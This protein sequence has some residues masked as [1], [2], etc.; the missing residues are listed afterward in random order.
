MHFRYET[1]I[2]V[3]PEEIL[4]M[5]L[6]DE[7]E[8]QVLADLLSEKGVTTRTLALSTAEEAKDFIDNLSS[9]E[10]EGLLQVL[11]D[12]L[13]DRSGTGLEAMEIQ[14][15][16]GPYSAHNILAGMQHMLLRAGTEGELSEDNA[17]QLIG[18]A[19]NY[20]TLIKGNP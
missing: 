15:T 11:V 7:G 13:G 3:T 1:D 14:K 12:L 4:D 8:L 9:P 6:D 17:R 16:D 2:E 18:M 5:T 20:L 19:T 10:R